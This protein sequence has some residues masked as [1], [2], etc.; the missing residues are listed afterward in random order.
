MSPVLGES[1][2]GAPELVLLPER[3][4]GVLDIRK[5]RGSVTDFQEPDFEEVEILGGFGV[6]VDV[7][8]VAK[9]NQVLECELVEESLS[10]EVCPR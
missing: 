9:V 6:I 4:E 8:W 1:S 5:H 7:S 3:E 2:G 10:M